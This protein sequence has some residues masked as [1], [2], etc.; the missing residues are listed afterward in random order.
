[1]WYDELNL[2]SRLSVDKTCWYTVFG[3]P[4]LDIVCCWFN[5]DNYLVGR[6]LEL[7]LHGKYQRRKDDKMIGHAARVMQSTCRKNHPEQTT[8][9][10]QLV[11]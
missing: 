7:T 1:M 5:F 3:L 6:S 2:G 4:A 8:R 9:C 10:E 11:Y